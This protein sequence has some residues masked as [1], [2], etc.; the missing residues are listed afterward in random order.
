MLFISFTNAQKPKF[1]KVTQS[2]L[3][4]SSCAYDENAKAEYLFH[5]CE[6]YFEYDQTRSRFKIIYSYHDRIKIYNEA[7]IDLAD[8]TIQYYAEEI[9]ASSEKI[10][11]LEAY[12]FN[13]ENGKV[14]NTKL[15]KDNIFDEKINDYY[16]AKKFAMPAVKPG[17]VLEIKYKIASPYYFNVNEFYFQKDVPVQYALYKVSTPEYFNYNYNLKGLVKLE[18]SEDQ[19]QGRVNFNVAVNGPSDAMVVK[20]TRKFQ[21]LTY[22][23]KVKTYSGTNIVGIKDEPFVYSM[24]NFKTS[25]KLELLFT[26]FPQAGVKYFTKTWNDIT[27]LLNNSQSFGSQLNK[28]YE[29]MDPLLKKVESMDTEEKIATIY[30]TIQNQFAWDGYT[31]ATTAGGIKEMIK[32][33]SGNTAE[34]NLLLVNVL[35]KAGIEAYPMVY[36][37]R[38]SGYL[39]ITNP[40]IAELDYVVAII[41][42][43]DSVLYLDATDK[44]LNP[45]MLPRRGL[46]LRGVVLLGEEGQ[47]IPINN[48][49][50]GSNNKLYTLTYDGDKLIG[51]YQQTIKGYNAY[52]A[53]SEHNSVNDLMAQ[54]QD[55][56]ITFLNSETKGFE[57]NQEKISISSDIKLK[58]YTQSI[59]GK[60]FIDLMV[61]QEKFKNPFTKMEREF[62]LFFDAKESE[63]KII[64]IAIPEGYQVETIPEALKI[65]TPEGQITYF[66]ESNV[67]GNDI[68]TSIRYKLKATII[69]PSDYTGVKIL[70]DAVEAKT[71]EKIVLTKI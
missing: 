6:T 66:V 20:R 45:G 54:L 71:K 29:E 48:F 69:N 32:E 41:V 50:K 64:K 13:L 60:L 40:T 22:L 51:K 15:K 53:R 38:S 25:I 58:G 70:F 16:S 27:E 55:D 47:Q 11:N 31:G 49:N 42:K 67:V 57:N 34:I 46:N 24:D 5:G 43:D 68:V 37:K 18:T 3:E 10:T 7:G 17:S 26:Q 35:Q 36:K 28:N 62:A 4:K 44:N 39:N 21:T 65:S 9:N 61:G 33:G 14:V 8:Q 56:N 59:D 30:T 52:M 19:S 23:E 1:K 12:T 2:E 63:T